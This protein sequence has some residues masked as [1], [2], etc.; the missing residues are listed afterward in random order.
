MAD[1]QDSTW[2]KNTS[3][4]IL[5]SFL[6]GCDEEFI[7][8][9]TEDALR[10]GLSKVRKLAI[11]SISVQANDKGMGKIFFMGHGTWEHG[12]CNKGQ[13]TGQGTRVMVYGNK[14][15]VWVNMRTTLRYKNS[16]F[17]T[18]II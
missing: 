4:D 18:I 1:Y 15:L 16:I 14:I 2:P 12:S 3:T 11:V 5:I 6:G 8:K 13:I 7:S 17:L 10:E 9:E